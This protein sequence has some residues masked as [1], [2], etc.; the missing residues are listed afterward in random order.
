M[1]G[2]LSGFVSLPDLSFAGTPILC[3][4]Q[5]NE[6]HGISHCI[7]YVSLLR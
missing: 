7:E 1:N 4:V 5:I 3:C 2:G 6:T